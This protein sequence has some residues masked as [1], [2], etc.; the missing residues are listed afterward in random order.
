MASEFLINWIPVLL[1]DNLQ[2]SYYFLLS[3][4]NSTRT[5]I[6]NFADEF[7]ILLCMQFVDLGRRVTHNA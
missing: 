7:A 5:L 6:L 3:Q 2:Y 4:L 1:L